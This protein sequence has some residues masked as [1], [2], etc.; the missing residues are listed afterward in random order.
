VR[1]PSFREQAAA[2]LA[3]RG[4]FGLDVAYLEPIA[5]WNSAVFRVSADVGRYALRVHAPTGRPE[6]AL[7]RELNFLG[8]LIGHGVSVPEP[9]PTLEGGDV[10]SSLDGEGRLWR[11]DLTT[12]LDGEVRRRGLSGQDADRLGTTLARIHVV[13]RRFAGGAWETDG[14]GDP[15][16]LL[17]GFGA[18][19][20]DG[21]HAWLGPEDRALLSEVGQRIEETLGGLAA[22]DVVSGLLHRDFILGNCLWSGE[23]LHVL[24]FADCGVGP[25][26]YDLAPMLTN[27][28][29]DPV[30]REAFLA[31]YARH[32]PLSDAQ[33]EALPMLEAARHASFCLLNIERARRGVAT[34]P[35]ERHLPVRMAEIRR[36]LGNV[37]D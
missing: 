17:R 16:G 6:A 18:G 24:D 11:F 34:P 27:I 12:W 29:D 19:E 8:A 2:R 22:D 23:A 21:T 30:L 20:L 1:V 37:R 28:G 32:L 14:A 25:L 31:G 13:A 9:V 35:L 3:A 5:S 10:F 26:L 36:L 4:G 33:Q 7:R 15:V